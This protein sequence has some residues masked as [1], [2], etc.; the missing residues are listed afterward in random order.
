ME[1]GKVHGEGPSGPLGD[2]GGDSLILSPTGM[3]LVSREAVTA[4]APGFFVMDSRSTSVLPRAGNDVVG[5]CSAVVT[6]IA[7]ADVP[8]AS[9]MA[10]VWVTVLAPGSPS[11]VVP[12]PMLGTA[13][14]G[15]WGGPS[16]GG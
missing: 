14:L 12:G 10:W 5:T 1:C 13:P 4:V 3:T 9:A 15:S 6:S 2:V 8:G 11:P 16:R 7:I